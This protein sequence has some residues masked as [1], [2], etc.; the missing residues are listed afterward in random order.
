MKNSKNW[1]HSWPDLPDITAFL[2]PQPRQR[3]GYWLVVKEGDSVITKRFTS[4]PDKLDIR[5]A[6]DNILAD[7]ERN[8]KIRNQQC[9]DCGGRLADNT[10]VRPGGRRG[11]NIS[12]PQCRKVLVWL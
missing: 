9:P 6:V 12:C 7:R 4:D 5:A 10:F 3:I 11:G 2:L 8:R 1:I